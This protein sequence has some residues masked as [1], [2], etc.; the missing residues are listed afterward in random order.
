[1]RAEIDAFVEGRNAWID[2]HADDVPFAYRLLAITPRHTTALDLEAG[3]LPI[4]SLLAY[5]LPEESLYLNLASRLTPEGLAELLPVYPGIASELPPTAITVAV[6][7]ERLSFHLTPGLAR[8][9]HFGLAASNNWVVDGTRSRSGRPMLANDP[10]LP[11]SM[12]S[13]W[14]EAVLITP[15]GFTAGAIPAGGMTV[16]I[17]TNGRVAWGVTSAQADVMDLSVEKLSADGG[18]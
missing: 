13:I 12:P 16:A 9:D 6:G 7:G 2:Q 18:S 14:Y 3:A 17:G 1:M 8:R 4:A 11:Q 5:N 15:D 10:H